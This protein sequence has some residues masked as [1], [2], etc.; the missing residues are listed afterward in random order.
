MDL[1]DSTHT[2]VPIVQHQHMPLRFYVHKVYKVMQVRGRVQFDAW[3][4]FRKPDKYGQVPPLCHHTC[5]KYKYTHI[6]RRV[7][8]QCTHSKV[9]V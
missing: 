5:Y 4:H 7:M 3:S 6:P 8:Y 1:N 2:N 9:Y